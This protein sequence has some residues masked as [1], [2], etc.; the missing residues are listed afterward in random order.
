MSCNISS[1]GGIAKSFRSYLPQSCSWLGR[2]LTIGLNNINSFFKDKILELFSPYIFGEKGQLRLINWKLRRKMG[3]NTLNLTTLD[4]R[5]IEAQFIKHH[6]SKEKNDKTIILFT[7][8]FSSYEKYASIFIESYV[9][10]NFNVLCLNY[11]GFGNSSGITSELT[12]QLDAE[13]AYNYLSKDENLAD[14]QIIAHGY[15]LG[16]Y[17]ATYLAVKYPLCGLIFDRGFSSMPDVIYDSTS[18]L[19]SLPG[20]ASVAYAL[21]EFAIPLNNENLIR[22]VTSTVL[23][24]S[25]K[26][27]KPYQQKKLLNQLLQGTA[28][29]EFIT[30]PIS[31]F[32]NSIAF[33]NLNLFRK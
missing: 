13:A 7:G 14:D 2:G 25:G 4:N 26:E 33:V 10:N 23:L 1:L 22:N 18:M 19:T 9:E 30:L 5:I 16:S 6:N 15:S 12:L 8:S 3:G 20:A 32:D 17:P 27:D 28:F 31:H 29:Y 11:G 21:A 24:I